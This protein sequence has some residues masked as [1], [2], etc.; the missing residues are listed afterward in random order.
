MPAWRAWAVADH[1]TV[2][3]KAA[4]GNPVHRGLPSVR[5][6]SLP[7][8]CGHFNA[9]QGRFFRGNSRCQKARRGR[10][11][12]AGT[13]EEPVGRVRQAAGQGIR[14][15]DRDA[16]LRATAYSRHPPPCQGASRV[17]AAREWAASQAL[18]GRAPSPVSAAFEESAASRVPVAFEEPAAFRAQ[19]GSAGSPAWALELAQAGGQAAWAD[20]A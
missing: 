19:A 13:R 10:H 9:I 7:A 4:N 8:R 14:S 5:V 16:N 3:R 6:S 2:A 1:D 17:P 11:G 12:L 20:S 15:W 18:V